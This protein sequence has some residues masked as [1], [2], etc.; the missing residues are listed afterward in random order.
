M[1]GKN[2]QIIYPTKPFI[3]RPCLDATVPTPQECTLTM[4]P[5]D[6]LPT[7]SPFFCVPSP[8]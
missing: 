2:G 1:Q 4:Q 8:T 5:C 6:N 3:T 7:A